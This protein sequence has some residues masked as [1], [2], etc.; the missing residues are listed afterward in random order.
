MYVCLIFSFSFSHCVSTLSL[1]PFMPHLNLFSTLSLSNSPI[2]IN[3]L[4]ANN[5]NAKFSFVI[6]LWLRFVWFPMLVDFISFDFKIVV[7]NTHRIQAKSMLLFIII[8]IQTQ[9]GNAVLIGEQWLNCFWKRFQLSRDFIL[10]ALVRLYFEFTE[11]NERLTQKVDITLNP[12][13]ANKW[14]LLGGWIREK[15]NLDNYF[16]I[17]FARYDVFLFLGKISPSLLWTRP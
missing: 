3:L 2:P 7:F 14:V 17:P 4:M 6:R 9:Q 8:A 11:Q 16:E 15:K 5:F 10:L 12:L 1:F 13:W